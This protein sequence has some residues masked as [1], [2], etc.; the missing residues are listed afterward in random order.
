MGLIEACNKDDQALYSSKLHYY[1]K[2]GDNISKVLRGRKVHSGEGHKKIGKKQLELRIF[3]KEKLLRISNYP[4][5]ENVSEL[6]C[7]ERIKENEIYFLGF[8]IA[9]KQNTVTIFDF[10]EV[11]NFDDKM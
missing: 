10:L 8:T 6:D 2:D 5:H 9:C 1:E 7:P 4:N 11:N 3:L